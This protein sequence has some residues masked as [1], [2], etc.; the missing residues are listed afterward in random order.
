MGAIQSLATAPPQSSTVQYSVV[1]PKGRTPI[2]DGASG[3]HTGGRMYMNNFSQLS[4][5][6]C[7]GTP[8]GSPDD[9]FPNGVSSPSLPIDQST[10]RISTS[11]LQGHVSAMIQA[12][13]IP[14]QNANFNAQVEADKAF[15][16]TVQSE[17]CF[18]ETRYSSALNT[19][20]TQISDPRGMAP[21]DTQKPLNRI[22]ALNRRLNSLLEI[23]QYVGNDRAQKVNNRSKDIDRANSDL[24]E[25]IDILN[26]Q[27]DY[28]QDSNV[29]IR[30]QE[31]MMR[32][33]SEKNR[34]MNI[35]IMF[36]VALNIVALGTVA[37]VYSNVK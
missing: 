32:F 33:S 12:G 31:E 25:K 30:T 5:N 4:K 24:Q 14:G 3:L 20:L 36:F 11:A 8:G 1:L 2:T 6:I 15:Y 18:Y 34:A 17:Y 19:F 28:L 23:I 22:V 35:Q 26:K 10:G 16:A 21:A 9:I 29:H 7:D 37:T 27:R 13:K